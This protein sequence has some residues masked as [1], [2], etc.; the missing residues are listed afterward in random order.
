MKKKPTHGGKRKGSGRPT[1]DPLKI[2]K[3]TTMRVPKA[4]IGEIREL[5]ELKKNY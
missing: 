4:L 3:T 5:I 2:V 1:K